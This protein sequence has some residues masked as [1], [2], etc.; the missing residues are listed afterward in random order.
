MRKPKL[1]IA[2]RGEIAC[3][4][5]AAARLLGLPTVAVH[6]APDAGLPHV[7]L[8]D[9]ACALDGAR[10]QETYLDVDRVLA[11][12]RETGAT[13]LHPGYGFLSENAGFARR[14]RDEGI[15][16]VGPSPEAIDLMGDKEQARRTAA[17]AG[18]PVLPGTAR[19]PEDAEGL[20]RAA[21]ELEYPLL[22][23]SSAGGGGIGM[24]IVKEPGELEAAVRSTRALA[25]KA[26]GD[27]AVYLERYV[28][29]ARHVEVQVFGFGDGDAV[30]LYERDCSLQRRHQKVIEEARA[31]GLSS[32]L[33]SDIARA[34]VALAKA[35]RYE[36]AGTVEFLVD[37]DT[38][39]F[40]FLEMNTRIQ[41]EHPVT[42][43][44]TGVDLVAAQLRQA[45][46]ESLHGE[47]AQSAIRASGHAVE[48]R[49]YAENPA[50]N[51]LPSPGPLRVLELPR[52]DGVRVDCGYAAGNT[53]TPYYDPMIMKVIAA[54]PTRAAAIDRLAAA[55]RDL[56]IEGVA[57]NAA[58]LLA[59]LRH[60]EFASGNVYTAF[61]SDRHGDIVAGATQ[62]AQS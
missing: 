52:S 60:P 17:A 58:Y 51:F 49:V 1:L 40:Y 7:A 50:K 4:V 6:S 54:G 35:C 56:R 32:E 47:L 21:R 39:R 16:F 18:V 3:R 34:A 45:L 38:G 41:V 2:N 29:R 36:G 28:A 61:L 30:H 55:L 8:A 44:I 20:A 31:P 19:L 13:L 53:V 23:K 59:C 22:V 25:G 5:L 33:T 9:E 24:R 12:A 37:A 48:A 11:A 42:E 26:F 62:E 14:C 43:M 15:V 27:D 10:A 46:G 57:N